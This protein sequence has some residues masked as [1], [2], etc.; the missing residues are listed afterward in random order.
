MM[1]PMK[2]CGTAK[3]I[4]LLSCLCAAG[5]CGSSPSAPTTDSVQILSS[6]PPMGTVLQRGARMTFTYRVR[7][8]LTSSTAVAAFYLL[9]QSPTVGLD[10]PGQITTISRGTTELTMTRDYTIPA[11]ATRLFVL[12]GMANQNGADQTTQEFSYTVQ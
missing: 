3:L 7:F 1:M 2:H 10:D 6:S 12:I 5:S 8:T 4:T 9:P 11:D